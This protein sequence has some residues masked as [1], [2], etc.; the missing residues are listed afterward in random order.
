[1]ERAFVKNRE[2]HEED[3][4]KEGKQGDKF[5]TDDKSVNGNFALSSFEQS[6]HAVSSP[7]L[8]DFVSGSTPLSVVCFVL[9]EQASSLD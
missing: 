1:M 3:T 8:R 7:P 2:G 9:V 6:F 4:L 5:D